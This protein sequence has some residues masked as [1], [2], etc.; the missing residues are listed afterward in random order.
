MASSS[1]SSSLYDESGRVVEFLAANNFIMALEVAKS[2]VSGH[3][4]SAL[5]N[6]LTAL[7]L[8]KISLRDSN[9]VRRR[10]YIASALDFSKTALALSPKSI[11]FG[12]LNAKIHLAN[13][14]DDAA[15][16]E[17][18]SAM[19]IEDPRDPW[20]DYLG[21]INEGYDPDPQESS[22][23]SRI[24]RVRAE[25]RKLLVKAKRFKFKRLVED[26]SLAETSKEFQAVQDRKEEI[27][28]RFDRESQSFEKMEMPSPSTSTRKL[29][30]VL[31]NVDMITQARDYWNNVMSLEA[32]KDFLSVRIEKFFHKNKSMGVK[33]KEVLAE[34]V[35]Y[36][37]E[38]K[39]WKFST[40]CC[41]GQR[42]SDEE[43]NLEH[44]KSAHLGTL[45][46][47]LQSVVPKIVPI[48]EIEIGDWRP[49]NVVA[50]AKLIEDLSRNDAGNEGQDE[51]KS[52]DLKLENLPRCND[53]NRGMLIKSIWILLQLFI[54]IECFA[55]S[56]FYMLLDLILEMLKNQIPETLL[57]Q[58]WMKTTLV[59]VWFL[60]EP[61][62]ESVQEFLIEELG[63]YCGLQ[64]LYT[65]CHRDKA[66]RDLTITHESIIFRDDDLSHL[67][68][69]LDETSELASRSVDDI[70]NVGQEYRDNIVQWLF[71]G[72]EPI[73]E[74][75]K[76]WEKYREA[77]KSLGME[78]FK[79]IESEFHRLQNMCERKCKYLRREKLWLDMEG[80]CLEEDKRRK[81]ISGIQQ[82]YR[83]LLL[84]RQNDIEK[85]KSIDEMGSMELDII[86]SILK[87]AQADNDI[88]M[89]FQMRI[90]QMGGKCFKSDATILATN[91]AMQQTWNKLKMAQLE[92]MVD[93]YATEKSNAEIEVLLS[94]LDL[95]A[96]NNTGRG[97]DDA[98][99]GQGK[100][101]NKKK[102]K[103]HRKAKEFK[104]TGGSEDQQGNVEQNS[105]PA[106]HGK[107]HPLNP[108]VVGPVTTAELDQEERE[109]TRK[110][111]EE[112]R[113]EEHQ[114]MLARHLEY[115]RQIEN[116]AKQKRLAEIDKA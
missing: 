48:S 76:K 59:S 114:R 71:T 61:E 101:K 56:H 29:K 67:I 97:G 111:E 26:H 108:E 85:E 105:V 24:E 37:K 38:M 7:T 102:K 18:E 28:T 8:M 70:K 13:A 80:I 34:A 112:C 95:N 54:E 16:Q 63:I 110:A 9:V 87:K 35:E 90:D 74:K 39:S 72:G 57:N 41:C 109:L 46:E 53:I 3:P 31:S 4:D 12:F 40:C 55:P 50:A 82:S 60:D 83:S 19:S 106:T 11:A 78:L 107:D 92:D 100:S 94:K 66:R 89:L 64:G 22:K 43:L 86:E 27:Q 52:Q 65:S 98:R 81:E 47:E 77:S 91:V 84:K 62:L 21:I 113:V 93:K 44:I 96:K 10:E 73:G 116:E 79:I 23:E 20:L 14:H 69:L 88:K 75:L 45:S 2:L 36:A 99:Q 33:A 30:K 42:F 1:S 15:I 68:P 104:A 25:L 49:V 6:A 51:G 58:R 5:A 17:C 103:D 32:K 115:Q